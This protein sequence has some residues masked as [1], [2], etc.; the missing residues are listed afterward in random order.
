MLSMVDIASGDFKQAINALKSI[1]PG[2]FSY[3]HVSSIHDGGVRRKTDRLDDE[4]V[5]K[6]RDARKSGKTLPELS[7]EYSM[8]EAVISKLTMWTTYRYLDIHL[9]SEYID[10]YMAH[11]RIS[12]EQV[13]LIVKLRSN[14]ASVRYISTKTGI[15]SS[16]LDRMLKGKIGYLKQYY[17]DGTIPIE[18]KGDKL[19]S[20]D[21]AIKAR[22]KAVMSID[23]IR[24]IRNHR[25]NGLSLREISIIEKKNLT[26][27]YQI[28]VWQAY[29]DVDP[30]LK[31][32]YMAKYKEKSKNNAA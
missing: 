19:Y 17:Q 3:E 22:R 29:W 12:D 18:Y 13:K 32:V 28:T 6:I 14:G 21:G 24:E 5:R 4:L 7:E 31:S 2:S 9:R 8:D 16:T 23:K 25:Y 15:H 30:E 26:T 1:N 10:A 27:V 11:A 20:Y